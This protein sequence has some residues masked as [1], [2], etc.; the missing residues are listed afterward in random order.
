MKKLMVVLVLGLVSLNG[1]AQ[2]VEPFVYLSIPQEKVNLGTIF[3]YDTIIPQALTIKVNSNCM[4]GSV[5]ASV[6]SLKNLIGNEISQD[7]LFIKTAFTGS[8][9]SLLNP[10]VISE[11]KYGS[12]DIVV[13]FKVQANGANDRAGKYY[14]TIAFTVM[15]LI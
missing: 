12:H 13:D 2:A 8:F 15:P 6:S 14:G 7:R 11:P 5:V 9:V 4:H 10:V 1:I 3:V